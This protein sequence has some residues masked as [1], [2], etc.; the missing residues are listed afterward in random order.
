MW[1]FKHLTSTWLNSCNLLQPWQYLPPLCVCTLWPSKTAAVTSLNTFLH[2]IKSSGLRGIFSHSAEHTSRLCIQLAT[3]HKQQQC[4]AKQSRM[5]SQKVKNEVVNY[6][7]LLECHSIHW[8]PE[9]QW[10]WCEHLSWVHNCGGGEIK[11]FKK[12]FYSPGDILCCS[13]LVSIW[14]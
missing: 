14:W 6:L 2:A 10:S 4:T 7:E 11:K 5:W 12:K 3:Q 8:S 13:V 9:P 1:Q